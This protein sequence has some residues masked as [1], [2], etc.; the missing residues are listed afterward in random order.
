VYLG[1]GDVAYVSG[2]KDANPT[3]CGR[4]IAREALIDPEPTT[5]LGYEA[6]FLGDSKVTRS[7]DPADLQISARSRRIARADRL[8]AAGTGGADQLRPACARAFVQG[9]IIS[10]Q[11]RN[12]RDRPAIRGHAEQRQKRRLEPGHVARPACVLAA[13]MWI[14]QSSPDGMP[15][16]R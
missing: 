9:R 4:S 2:I 11:R 15:R 12:A 5:T 8:I 7:G 1:S 14:G 6:V 16:A 13:P 3:A 10:K